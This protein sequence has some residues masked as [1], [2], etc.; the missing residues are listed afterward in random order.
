MASDIDR[1]WLYAGSFAT[2]NAT[3]VASG[4][5]CMTAPAEMDLSAVPEQVSWDMDQDW[6]GEGGTL[7]PSGMPQIYIDHLMPPLFGLTYT[8]LEPN[9]CNIST[10]ESTWGDCAQDLPGVISTDGYMDRV[11]GTFETI[12]QDTWDGDND[13]YHFVTQEA[14]Y[15]NGELDWETESGDM[16]WY[17]LCYFGDEFNPWNWYVMSG[18]TVDLSKPEIGT[19]V[20]PVGAGTECY[21][22]TVGYSGPAGEAY[23]LKLWMTAE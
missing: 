11:L 6:L 3:G 20:V 1:V 22:W 15:I 17:M 12:V 2:L 9:D 7:V 21:A 10:S 18:D 5:I 23:K 19:S 16:D 4:D 13:T 14:G 8:D